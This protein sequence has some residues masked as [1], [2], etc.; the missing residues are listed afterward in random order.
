MTMKDCLTQKSG[1]GL[2][3]PCMPPLSAACSADAPH[4]LHLHQEVGFLIRDENTSGAIVS[5]LSTDSADDAWR[6]RR[7]VWSGDT[8]HRHSLLVFTPLR[9]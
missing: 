6:Y 2:L 8:E 5:R 7:C 9:S 4:R 3:L 1:W